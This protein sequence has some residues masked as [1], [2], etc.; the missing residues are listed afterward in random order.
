MTEVGMTSQ[1]HFRPSE[2]Q[3]KRGGTRSRRA[4]KNVLQRHR[5][6]S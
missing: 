6:M 3:G 2:C 1:I 5:P 4:E